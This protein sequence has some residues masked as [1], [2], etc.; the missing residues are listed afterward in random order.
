MNTAHFA[1]SKI[2]R[3]TNTLAFVKPVVMLFAPPI[4]DRTK[5]RF[6]SPS[7]FPLGG[8]RAETRIQKLIPR[9]TSCTLGI[10]R[11]GI[12]LVPVLPPHDED[13]GNSGSGKELKDKAAVQQHLLE[14]ARHDHK[15]AD[16]GITI[17]P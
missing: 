15:D 11:A 5:P 1:A 4:G 8:R 9:K 2:S 14:R 10:A 12:T 7:R 17:P 16:A 13:A 3:I 6:A